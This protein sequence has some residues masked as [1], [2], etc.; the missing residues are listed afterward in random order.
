MI[1]AIKFVTIPITD[2]NRALEFYTKKLGFTVFTDQPMGEDMRWIELK[3]G[4][5]DTMIVLFTAD[6]HRGWIGKP[7]NISFRC[8]N[9]EK[10]VGELLERGVEFDG[11][12]EKHDWGW[13]AQFKDPDGNTFALTD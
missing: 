12:P 9:M 4:R 6:V 1:N 11:K 2:Q 3:L 10:T 5:S 13:H 8:D 7:L